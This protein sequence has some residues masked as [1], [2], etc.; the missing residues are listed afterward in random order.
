MHLA[1]RSHEQPLAKKTKANQRGSYAFS[2][3]KPNT[4]QPWCEGLRHTNEKTSFHV[5]EVGRAFIG[6]VSGGRHQ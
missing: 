1:L 6:T 3:N 5:S 2:G 4:E